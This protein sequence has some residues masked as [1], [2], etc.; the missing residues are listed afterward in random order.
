[1]SFRPKSVQEV[2]RAIALHSR[3][4]SVVQLS[5]S[6]STSCMFLLTSCSNLKVSPSIKMHNTN[7]QN[8]ICFMR[9]IFAEPFTQLGY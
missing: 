9:C 1:M 4:A 6:S 8:V 2:L 3:A 7:K 5:T